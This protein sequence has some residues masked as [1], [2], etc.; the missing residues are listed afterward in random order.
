M[1]IQH[2]VTYHLLSTQLLAG[3][4][5]FVV[6]IPYLNHAQ[7]MKRLDKKLLKPCRL[8]PVERTV[9]RPIP[10]VPE[11]FN[12]GV[13]Y[14]DGYDYMQ[15]LKSAMDFN[16]QTTFRITA[17]PEDKQAPDD[18]NIADETPREP[19]VDYVEE[20]P[21]GLLLNS[22]VEDESEESELV[23]NFV[24]L[25]GGHTVHDTDEDDPAV[26]RVQPNTTSSSALKDL[27]GKDKV[28]MMERFLYGDNV[29]DDGDD[30]NVTDD[31]DEDYG[32]PDDATV[33]NRQFE[34]LVLRCKNRA[35]SASQSM[36]TGT[37]MMSEGL[38]YALSRDVRMLPLPRPKSDELDEL[39]D[40]LRLK[41]L[42][43][44]DLLVQNV[45]SSSTEDSEDE[46][47]EPAPDIVSAQG[48]GGSNRKPVFCHLAVPANPNKSRASSKQVSMENLNMCTES[49]HFEISRRIDPQLFVRRKGE[50][51]QEKHLRKMAVRQHRLERR[52]IKKLNQA[53]FRLE[54]EQQ[55]KH[56][57]PTITIM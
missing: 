16:D 15:H 33:L 23:D 4:N 1:L 40:E 57:V 44:S 36:V 22:D 35:G 2:P 37:S 51:S 18:L 26:D 6:F 30:D 27:L 46:C 21:E 41:T 47:F 55:S 12:Y 54:Q 5:V 20:I 32:N 43:R 29:K 9:A 3:E 38:Q 14:D 28:L 56:R 11:H 45:P 52:K 49:A 25:A 34:K 17:I 39:D 24:E 50:T 10:G 53:N 31:S 13:F 48:D 42:S 19:V 7:T 8:E